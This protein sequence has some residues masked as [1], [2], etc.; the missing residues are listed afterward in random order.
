M[1]RKRKRSLKWTLRLL[2]II[3][4]IFWVEK[5]LGIDSAGGPLVAYS[6]YI[7]H[8]HQWEG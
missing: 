3:W 2:M 7:M 5:A 8:F 4:I 1:P 6:S